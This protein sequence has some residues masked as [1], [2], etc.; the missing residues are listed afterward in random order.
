ME[1]C[2]TSGMVLTPEVG[3]QILGTDMS[4]PLS[5]GHVGIV[6]GRSSS[7]MKGLIVL[8]GVI[9]PDY[10]GQIKLLCYSLNGVISIAPGDRLAQL[11][12]LPSQ[13]EKFPSMGSSRGSAGLGSTGVDLACLSMALDDRPVLQLIIEGRT[14]SGLV[15][16]G[17]DRSII[18]NQ[19]WLNNGPCN[20]PP[21]PYRGWDLRRLHA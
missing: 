10:T 8:P 13:H 17:A 19:D 4:S 21:S 9:D 11:L 2:A 7:T 20:N 14:F 16:T 15:D 18:R 1:L 12:I 3:V 5:R 6:L